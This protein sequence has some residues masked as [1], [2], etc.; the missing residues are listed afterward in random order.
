M[1]DG[2][3]DT[4]YSWA[5]SYL[6]FNGAVTLAKYFPKSSG[7]LQFKIPNEVIKMRVHAKID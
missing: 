4:G 1:I 2:T 5:L 7:L 3:V 6:Y